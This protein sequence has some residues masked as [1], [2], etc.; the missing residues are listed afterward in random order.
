M[1]HKDAE[2]CRSVPKFILASMTLE[3]FT[4]S[5]TIFNLA[6]AAIPGFFEMEEN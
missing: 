6:R 4:Q 2:K 1:L 3:E 5:T